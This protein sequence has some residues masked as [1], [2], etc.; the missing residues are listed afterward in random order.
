MKQ[1]FVVG[2]EE[3]KHNVEVRET[4]VSR[5]EHSFLATGKNMQI[6]LAL[7]SIVGGLVDFRSI[8]LCLLAHL[9]EDPALIS[10]LTAQS[11]NAATC[12][13]VFTLLAAQWY[14]H[15]YMKG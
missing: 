14:I 9:S 11:R 13:D 12:S 4:V 7:Y 2:K 8:E 3:E 1:Q 5:D 6:S 15:N 10:I